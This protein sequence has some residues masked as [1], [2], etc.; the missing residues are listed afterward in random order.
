MNLESLQADEKAIAFVR[1][2]VE[3]SKPIGAVSQGPLLLFK[4]NAV[5][6]RRLTSEPS[7]QADLSNAEENGSTKKS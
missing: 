7:L 3:S 5:A 1:S 2:F 6:G 4:A